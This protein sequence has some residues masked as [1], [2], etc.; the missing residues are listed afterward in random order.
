MN[1]DAPHIADDLSRGV[2]LLHLQIRVR[3]QAFIIV[4]TIVVVIALGICS[5]TTYR[6]S[7]GIA[8][9]AAEYRYF[10]R[11]WTNSLQLKDL[12]FHPY[13]TPETWTT[14]QI[15]TSD[16][17]AHQAAIAASNLKIGEHYALIAAP[18]L[19]VGLLIVAKQLGASARHAKL[20]RG[21]A[22]VSDSELAF[23]VEASGM[24]SDLK[25]GP[26]PLIK[27]KETQHILVMG[28]VGSGKTQTTFD[29]LRHGRNCGE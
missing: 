22:I 20:L 13:S 5:W 8:V 23:A 24:A 9:E 28:T 10:A 11:Y 18:F 15:S 4:A 12:Y 27:G 21:R 19:V 26:V 25:V 7:G 1:R 6:L 17:F 3:L 2:G 16:W 14:T 29:A